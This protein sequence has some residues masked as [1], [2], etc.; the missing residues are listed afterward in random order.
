M[1]RFVSLGD[2]G[3]V[4]AVFLAEK[5]RSDNWIAS[6]EAQIG[7]SYED[8]VFTPPPGPPPEE[9]LAV[10]RARMVVSRFQAK[11]ALLQ[12]GLLDQVSA[13]LADADPVAQ[14]AWAEAVEFRRMSPTILGLAATIGLTDEQLDDLFR[15]A[16]EIEA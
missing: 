10:E 2:D 12:A 5:Q 15:A 14:L 7:W 9:I 1:R 11:A 3:T 16:A 13:A 6:E 8:G 4:G